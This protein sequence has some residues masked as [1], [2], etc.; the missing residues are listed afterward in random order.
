MVYD[1]NAHIALHVVMIQ[2][3][4]SEEFGPGDLLPET[5]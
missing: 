5:F 1:F 2:D 4:V 3:V